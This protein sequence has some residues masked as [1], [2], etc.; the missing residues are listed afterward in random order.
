M[1]IPQIYR[2]I[3][4]PEAIYIFLL[5]GPQRIIVIIEQKEMINVGIKNSTVLLFL[6]IVNTEARVVIENWRNRRVEEC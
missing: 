4:R 3:K 6:E 1:A 2:I 5:P